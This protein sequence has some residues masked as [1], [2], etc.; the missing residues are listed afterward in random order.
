MTGGMKTRQVATGTFLTASLIL[1]GA[2]LADAA[3]GS[4]PAMDRGTVPCD[5]LENRLEGLQHHLDALAAKRV[6]LEAR[7]AAAE[8][9]GDARR[10]RRIEAKL[11]QVDRAAAKLAA[12]MDAV[13]AVYDD[14]CEP[15]VIPE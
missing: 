15:Y 1:G 4:R 10:V 3:P 7:L 6:R 5:A 2:S 8:A 13:Q 9:D 11:A 12:V 14:R